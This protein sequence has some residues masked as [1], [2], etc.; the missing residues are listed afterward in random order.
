MSVSAE[1]N[2]TGVDEADDSLRA[3]VSSMLSGNY[4]EELYLWHVSQLCR[5]EPESAPKLLGIIDRYY[6]LGRMPAEQY[7][8][9]KAKLEQA[10]GTRPA[11]DAVEPDSASEDDIN[12][13]DSV[14]REL[15]PVRAQSPSQIRGLHF[16][17]SPDAPR[18]AAATAA[19]AG[20]A[21]APPGAAMQS[22][23]PAKAQPAAPSGSRPP[24]AAA[25]P[26]NIGIG[27]VLRDRYE[28]LL[29]LGRG[30]MASVFNA[31]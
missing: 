30:G 18:S 1:L 5:D 15:G 14:T 9:L 10:M 16:A 27:T 29:L 26:I 8:K 13:E 11:S 3:L 17:A 24:S 6:R 21:A 12:S 23:M 20:R 28:L 4:K 31:A 2:E 22:P 7:Q 19:S 25:V